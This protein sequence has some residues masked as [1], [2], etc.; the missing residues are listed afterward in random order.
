[1]AT[2]ASANNPIL[3][4][5]FSPERSFGNG[6]CGHCR[7]NQG[8]KLIER[9][10]QGQIQPD[11]NGSPD[12]PAGH[13]GRF[14]GPRGESREIVRQISGVGQGQNQKFVAAVE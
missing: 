2:Q 4:C 13:S 9:V 7:L 12:P 6:R 14:P 5:I 10:L 8:C 3:K 1:M 11:L